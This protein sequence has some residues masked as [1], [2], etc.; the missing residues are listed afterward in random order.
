MRRAVLIVAAAVLIVAGSTGTAFAAHGHGPGPGK[1]CE[2][3]NGGT[4]VDLDGLAYACLLPANNF[5]ARRTCERSGGTFIDLDG[6]TY[7]CLFPDGRPGRGP[8]H[9]NRLG[10]CERPNGGTL[11]DLDG[12]RLQR[13][14][15]GRF[16]VG[17]GPHRRQVKL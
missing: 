8:G 6:L 14:R 12:Q 2:R 16:R 4:F 1:V 9:G 10:H 13:V 5:G 7:V 17:D 15:P 11:I 3:F